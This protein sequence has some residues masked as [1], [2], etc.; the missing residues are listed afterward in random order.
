MI[1]CIIYLYV[2]VVTAAACAATLMVL[3]VLYKILRTKRREARL[4]EMV[5]AVQALGFGI[6]I[7]RLLYAACF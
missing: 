1:L 4:R 5:M 7:S 2:Y 6:S 3:F